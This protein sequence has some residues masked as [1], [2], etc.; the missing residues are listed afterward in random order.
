MAVLA[1][2]LGVRRVGTAINEVGLIVTELP[3]IE[4]TS[5]DELVAQ[6]GLLVEE[7]DV[8][9][10]VAGRPRAGSP[11]DELLT[12]LADRLSNV[13]LVLLDE[14]L[15]TKEAERQLASEGIRGDSDARA[16]SIL[17]EQYLVGRLHS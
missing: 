14:A 9:K 17:L 15:S 8:N 10:I 3:T 1:L 6:I 16:A 4:W 12:V 5:V 13:E 11:L 2:D 7:R